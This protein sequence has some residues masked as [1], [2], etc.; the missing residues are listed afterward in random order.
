VHST[1]PPA[2]S[3]SI[4]LTLGVIFG[5]SLTTFLLLVR[6]W[7]TQRQWVSLAEWARQ[8]DFK[9]HPTQHDLP[10]ALKNLA[11]GHLEEARG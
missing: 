3:W 2:F 6:R 7:T 1:Q 11:A 9:F 4:F 5:A 8:R 10:A